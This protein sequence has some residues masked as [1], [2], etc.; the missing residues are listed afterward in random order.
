MNKLGLSAAFAASLALIGCDKVA[1]QQREISQIKIE[2]EADVMQ[3]EKECDA[4]NSAHCYVLG[5]LYYE[6]KIVPQDYAR[7]MEYY[8]KACDLDNYHACKFLGD[9]YFLGHGVEK[10]PKKASSYYAKSC[11]ANHGL[12][13]NN[14]GWT[15]IYDEQK[16]DFKKALVLFDKGCYLDN[17]DACKFIAKAY[18]EGKHMRQDLPL[19]KEYFGKACDLGDTEGCDEYRRLN[20]KG[21]E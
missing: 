16:G 10:D 20:E 2:N 11:S 4:Q 3:S 21:I 17:A 14:L 15:V 8:T 6:G 1:E 18:E 5:G 9:F 7:G 19:A 13:C 12:A